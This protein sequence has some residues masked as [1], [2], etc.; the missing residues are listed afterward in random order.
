MTFTSTRIISI[1]VVSLYALVSNDAWGKSIENRKWIL[2]ESQHFAI[3][4]ALTARK[5]EDMLKRL[6]AIRA[7]FIP[8]GESDEPDAKPTTIVLMRTRKDYEQLGLEKGYAGVFMSRLRQNT[9]VLNNDLSLSKSTTVLHEYVHSLLRRNNRFPFPKWYDEGYAEYV[10]ASRLSK[11]F[12]DIGMIDAGRAYTLNNSRWMPWEKILQSSGFRDLENL[13][14]DRF[15]AQS[16]LLVHFLHNQGNGQEFAHAGLARQAI[17][18]GNGAGEIEA[19]EIGFQTSIE[20]LDRAITKYYNGNRMNHVRYPTKLLLP[21]FATTTKRLSSAE[22]LIM[23]AQTAMMTGAFDQAWKWYAA[24]LEDD[25]ANALAYAGLANML[26]VKGAYEDAEAH[27]E[28]ALELAP[29][30]TTI[31]INYSYHWTA[32]RLLVA[33]ERDLKIAYASKTVDLVQRA[34]A[35]G[36]VTPETDTLLAQAYLAEGRDIQDVIVLLESAIT[37]SPAE[38]EPLLLLAQ[39]YARVGRFEE[40]V[41]LAKDVIRYEHDESIITRAAQKIIDVIEGLVVDDLEN[42]PDDSE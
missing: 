29:E 35:L 24:A 23:L 7:L 15:Y 16:W 10:S 22:V 37:K 5:T 11:S 3:H 28:R 8:A 32:K 17:A 31:L 39:S 38:Q 21:S 13:D 40:A 6:E 2:M 4:S 30:S 33:S 36:A 27:F 12:F 25:S 1:V 18:R 14:E 42:L 9:I 19:F 20:D 26:S 34:R 41:R